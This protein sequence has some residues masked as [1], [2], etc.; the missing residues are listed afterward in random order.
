MSSASLMLKLTLLFLVAITAVLGSQPNIDSS[1]Y[2]QI[3]S[4]MLIHP[5]LFK[6]TLRP[7]RHQVASVSRGSSSSINAVRI[8]DEFSHHDVATGHVVQMTAT[9]CTAPNIVYLDLLP[10]VERVQCSPDSLEVFFTPLTEAAKASATL[11]FGT[12]SKHYSSATHVTGG[13]KFHCASGTFV[14]VAVTSVIS[15]SDAADGRL[16]SIKL[17]TRND[18]QF[19][20][21]ST[22][23]KYH[24]ND[25]RRMHIYIQIAYHPT[26]F[27]VLSQ[28]HTEWKRYRRTQINIL[29]R[30][31]LPSRSSCRACV[32]QQRQ[33]LVNSRYLHRR[34]LPR[35]VF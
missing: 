32:L 12:K 13:S 31:H 30:S 17:A 8:L 16:L 1:N 34:V 11:T 26:P 21:A 6:T 4:A 27:L 5:H 33:N 25:F 19:M 15:I 24:P 9:M 20:F 23:Y 22:D 3:P 35:F 18:D 14:Q 28:Y 2:V 7:F 10:N 29:Q